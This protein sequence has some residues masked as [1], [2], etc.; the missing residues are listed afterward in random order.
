M[1]KKYIRT[2]LKTFPKGGDVQKFQHDFWNWQNKQAKVVSVKSYRSDPNLE[3]IVD[4]HIGD[5]ST[6]KIKQCYK[7]SYLMALGNPQIDFVV[8]YTAALGSIPLE[9]SWNFYKPKKI[10]FDITL[11]LCL[12]KDVEIEKYLQ[13]LKIDA[14]KATKI[15]LSN[16]FS[17]L[18]FLAAWYIEKEQKK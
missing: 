12:N 10:Y 2:M 1:L 7:N 9:H 17:I 13:I 16:D 11:E 8:G 15:I 18:G 5:Y 3:R 4:E 6:P 14:K